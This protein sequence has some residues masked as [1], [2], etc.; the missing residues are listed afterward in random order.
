[1]RFRRSLLR[2]LLAIL[3]FASAMILNRVVA[4][5]P[6][7]GIPS[8]TVRVNTRM[9]LVDVVVIDKQG[10]PVTGL[11]PQDFV[12][13]ENGKK[14]QI[15]AFT[16]PEDASK[17]PAPLPLAP[18]IYSNKPEYRSEGG[19]VTVLLLDAANTPFRDQ[20]YARWQ[21][22]KYVQE[23]LKP[24]QRVAVFTLT[25]Q[26][27]MLQDF[28]TDPNLLKAALQK[29]K[30]REQDMQSAVPPPLSTAIGTGA[31]PALTTTLAMMSGE[32]QAFQSIQV[33]Y[34]LDRRVG[35]TLDAMR[36]LARVLGGMPGRKQVVWLTATFPFDLI[37]ENRNV[38]EAELAEALP[39]IHQT[40]LN[41]HAAGALAETQRH[42]HTEEIREASA[43]L[44]AAQVAIYPVDVRGLMSGMEM[45]RE[46][47][48]NRQLMDLSQRAGTRMSDVASS[49]E[50]MREI[51]A[52]TG[53]KVYVNQNEIKAGVD[54]VMADNNASYTLGY[55]PE[56]KKWDGK[57]R[58][59]KVKLDKD[60]TQLRAR[61]GY[62]AIDPATIKDRDSDQQIAEAWQT[63]VPATLVTFSA[64]VKPTD[65][66][67]V[68][69]DFLVDAH[70]LTV[71]DSGGK[72][73]FD[74]DL[75]SA[76]FSAEGKMLSNHSQKIAQEFPDNV[77]Q[78]IMQQGMLVHMD[79][80]PP[81]GKNNQVRL[82]V[83]DNATGHIGTLNAAW[84]P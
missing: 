65:K 38:T 25:N 79:L 83:R 51:A 46:D 62:Y 16:T 5:E 60:G 40:G 61:R 52:E 29:I 59:I 22:L 54:L 49:Q 31:D 53:G 70:S 67:K 6:N 26:L 64:R 78:Q 81:Q 74:V 39:D 84:E 14:Q 33:S 24:D 18:G 42:A 32:A 48:A 20:A 35:V 82:A 55:Y 1:M 63:G 45:E 66:G 44:S 34:E 7:S 17:V 69:V 68:G 43:Q 21:M 15:A 9:V 71:K 77:Y 47:S 3:M 50:T 41:T 36:G 75:Y 80:D 19:P 28:T 12:I 11:K 76:M 37:P 27:R 30:P 57:F 72:K 13:E 58:T 2:W 56:N 10:K 73:K 23:Q 4:Q 8:P